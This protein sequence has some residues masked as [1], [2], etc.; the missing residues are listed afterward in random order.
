MIN[1]YEITINKLELASELA[2][3]KIS[4]QIGLGKYTYDE[5]YEESESEMRYTEKGQDE[6][7]GLYDHFLNLIETCKK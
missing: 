2:D 6:F 7:N 1:E 4:Y 3:M 5:I